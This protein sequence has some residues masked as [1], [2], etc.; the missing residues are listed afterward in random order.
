MTT[1]TAGPATQGTQAHVM[2]DE[3]VVSAAGRP[4]VRGT[5][6]ACFEFAMRYDESCSIMSA[7]EHARTWPETALVPYAPDLEWL[8]LVG[9]LPAPRSWADGSHT[10]GIRH[11]AQA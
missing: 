4:I 5:H 9:T 6:D 2:R 7:P 10:P 1:T 3:H 8:R 11:L